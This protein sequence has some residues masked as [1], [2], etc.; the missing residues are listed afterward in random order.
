LAPRVL[1]SDALSP[2]AVAIFKE[3]G[4]EVDFQPQLGKDR[5]K[6]ASVIGDFDGLAIRSA[7]K[8]TAK[9]LDRASKLKVIGR[10]G[11]G[12]DNID[13]PVATAKGVIV[14]NTPFGNS[15]TTAEHA[16][17]MLF[18]L[19]RQIPQADLSTQAGKW[20]KNR[21]MGVEI[22]GKV[23]GIIGCGNIG[24]VVAERA[25]GLHMHVITFDPFLSPERALDLGVEKVD[26]ETLLSRADFITLHTPMTPQ[27]K[28]ILSAENLGKTRKGVRIIN[29]ARGGLVDEKAL[30]A[31]LDSGHVAGAAFDV[32]VNE[33]ATENPLFGHPNV[34]C[35]PHLGASTSEAQDNVALQIAEQMSEY[36]I[37]GAIS[38]AVNFPSITAEE[39][40]KLKPYIALTDC[41]GSFA[42]Q[43]VD[44]GIK[45]VVITYEGGV[46][47]LKTKAL[48]ASAITGLLRPLLADVNVVSAPSVA[49]E[50]GIAIDEVTRA[51]E[52]DFESLITLSVETESHS[53]SVSGTVFHDGKPRIISINGIAVDAVVA[54]V[55]I[56]VSNEDKLG[57]IGHFANILGNAAVNI[58]TFSLGRDREG[59][60]AIALV[61]VDGTVP[62]KVLAEIE[63]LPG[64][65]EVK[66]LAF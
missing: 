30:R 61:E 14:M 38:N 48:T 18:A 13:I 34:V 52:T 11:I 63:T 8:V 2:A 57:F 41:L 16:I 21:F 56:Y 28:N 25:L 9:I 1:I 43:L 62:E 23:L 12:V 55:M 7:T 36:L 17:A 51:A 60:S 22:T 31:L 44:S 46:S 40:P 65:K 6:L 58:A 45:R 47:E 15:I 39:A 3:R 49:K 37:R 10:A 53:R 20:E 42:G 59:G 24:S 35:T 64:V 32:F 27:T 66:A 4:V 29:C 33:P 5:E 54:P 50:R 26:L 19:A